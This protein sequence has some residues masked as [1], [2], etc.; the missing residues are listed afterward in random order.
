[1]IHGFL[2][3][4]KFMTYKAF[5][6]ATIANLNCGFDVLGLALQQPG[7]EVWVT[8]KSTKGITISNI[9][10]IAHLSSDPTKNVAGVVAQAM[11]EAVNSDFG[12][13]MELH[14]GM[15]IG[16]GMGSSAA[17]SAAAAFATNALLGNP[18]TKA[19]LVTFAMEGEKL[20]S[21]ASHA[22]NVAPAIMGGIVLVRGY[23]PLDVVPLTLAAPLWAVVVHPQV[24]II[25]SESRKKL[26]PE[27]PL[28]SAVTQWG[29]LGGFVAGVLTGDYGLIGRSLQDVIIEPQRTP[30]IPKFDEVKAAAL[31]SG[32][33]GAGIA[34][35]GP[36]I[37][38]LCSDADIAARAA[39]TMSDVYAGKLACGVY[40]SEVAK[41]GA[42]LV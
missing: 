30:S 17:S 26:L 34:G 11:L 7:D 14:K 31:N 4:K 1:M 29:N 25:T 3:Y 21:G 18:F 20:A 41:E 42:R 15:V 35:S 8:P 27:V 28:K 22:D 16:T 5:A 10:G 38:A 37:F 13:T 36:S 9:T 24:E 2:F 39:K 40:V 19:E 32:A 12:L 23:E 33:L 6:P